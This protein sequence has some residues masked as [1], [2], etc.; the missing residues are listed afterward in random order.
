MRQAGYDVQTEVYKPT[1]LGARYIDINVSKNGANL[2]GIETKLGSSPYTTSQRAKDAWLTIDY[3]IYRQRSPQRTINMNHTH[4]DFVG[5]WKTDQRDAEAEPQD[6]DV[7]IDFNNDGTAKYCIYY[8][9]KRNVVHLTYKVDGDHR[10]RAIAPGTSSENESF[11]QCR[12]FSDAL[13][14]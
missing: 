11:L 3:R 10:D 6:G 7:T 1:G 9:D 13:V 8:S 5:S 12:R 2:G 14:Q 4:K